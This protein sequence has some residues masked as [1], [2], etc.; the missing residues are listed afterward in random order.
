MTRHQVISL[1]FQSSTQEYFKL[2]DL[3]ADDTGV[4]CPATKVIVAETIDNLLFKLFFEVDNIERDIERFSNPTRIINIVKGTT[5]T[6][7]LAM[8]IGKL[9]IVPDL[10][11]HTNHLTALLFKQS[12]SDR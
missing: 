12:R 11:R 3:V 10:H 2:E 8:F 6:K 5:R 4:R 9:G 1:K 7:A